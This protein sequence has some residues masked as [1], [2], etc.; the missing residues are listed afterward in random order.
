[1]EKST[2]SAVI[3]M[4]GLYLENLTERELRIVLSLI[5]GLIKGR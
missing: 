5:Q 2:K 1:M 4:I 3:E